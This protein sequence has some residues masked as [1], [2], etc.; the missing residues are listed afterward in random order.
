MAPISSS[1]FEA[2]TSRTSTSGPSEA[3]ESR[4][5]TCICWNIGFCTQQKTLT[6]SAPAHSLTCGAPSP[7]GGRFIER[8]WLRPSALVCKPTAYR[9]GEEGGPNYAR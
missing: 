5:A 7:H 2:Y 1:S 6:L 9:T 3:V 4:M 8:E